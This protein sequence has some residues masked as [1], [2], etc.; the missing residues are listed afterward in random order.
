M[1]RDPANPL[2]EKIDAFLTEALAERDPGA[3]ARR[4]G[5]AVYWNEILAKAEGDPAAVVPERARFKR[6]P[7]PARRHAPCLPVRRREAFIR[8]RGLVATSL[9]RRENALPRRDL[10][11]VHAAGG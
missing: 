1:P 3:R 11:C 9:I 4:L 7:E 8:V 6:S 2:L 5:R 10:V